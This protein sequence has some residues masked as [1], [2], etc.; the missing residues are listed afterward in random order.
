[1]N[2]AIRHD[3]RRELQFHAELFE[4]NGD[5]GKT[6]PRLDDWKGKLSP[7][8]EARFFAIYSNKVWLGKNLQKIPLLQGADHGAEMNIW[9]EQKYVQQVIYSFCAGKWRCYGRPWE[10]VREVSNLG[11]AKLSGGGV[12]DK[13][14]GARIKNVD[15]QLRHC[16]AVNFRKFYFE[17]DFLS[18]HWTERQDVH[19]ILGVG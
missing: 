7:C 4:R 9:P 8:Q 2:V 3:Y 17:Q 16:G 5:R 19:H 6:L 14:S 11:A 1:M 18:P 12:T 10:R 15:A 13:V